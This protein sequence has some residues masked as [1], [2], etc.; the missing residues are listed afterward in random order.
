MRLHDEWS[1]EALDRDPIAA[2]V[3]PFPCRGFLETWW[4]HR[5][6]GDL[7]LADDGRIA[8]P[9][10]LGRKGV[11]IVGEE[12]LTDY[13][14]PLGGSL[15]DLIEFGED[16]GGVLAPGVPFRLDSLPGEVALP[17][18]EGLN[19]GGVTTASHQHEAT[20]VLSL[21]FDHE[22]YLGGLRTKDRHE[23]R[24]KGRRFADALGEPHL[25][26]SPDGLDAF[27]A[28][29]QAAEGRKGDFMGD[30][31]VGFFGDLLGLNGAVLSVLWGD[32]APVAAAFGFE[33]EGAYY[34]YN[35]AYDPGHASASPG[36]TLIDRL[37]ATAIDRGKR[38]FDFL[39]GDEAYKFRMGAVARPLYVL[40]GTT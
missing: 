21:P 35:S 26:H 7:M 38:R 17:L 28:M 10:H 3:G 32:D 15:D 40:E 2:D 16:L 29:H 22:T 34:L 9:L 18:A 5:G 27:V 19:S 39:K 14:C 8:L 24:R 1:T 25:V 31:M 13:H 36:V 20:A 12:N 33:D 23:I 37:I 6:S 11:E 30:E 4:E